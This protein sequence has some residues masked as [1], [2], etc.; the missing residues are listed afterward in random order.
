MLIQAYGWPYIVK[1]KHVVGISPSGTGKT[2]T[3]LCPLISELLQ[4]LSYKELAIGNGVRCDLV[5][6][7]AAHHV[8]YR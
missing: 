3:F 2:F 6:V 8:V 1:L 7:L 5:S 4:P